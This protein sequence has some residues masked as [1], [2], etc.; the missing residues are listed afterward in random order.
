MRSKL[1]F[2]IIVSVPFSLLMLSCGGKDKKKD[3]GKTNIETIGPAKGSDDGMVPGI[4]TASLK[5]EA[6]ILDAMQK[7]VDA[8]IAD[9]KKR[10][11]DPSYAGHF[12]ELMTLHTAVLKASTAYSR[13]LND[14][15]RSIEFDKKINA[16]EDKLY[17]K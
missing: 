7:V 2:A 5:D 8:R 17:P 16:I 10:K 9:E 13:S 14:P 15:S 6:S 12:V 1:L 11:E 3:I 4:D